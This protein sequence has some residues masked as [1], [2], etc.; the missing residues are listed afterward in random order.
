MQF[1]QK[2]L[3]T[4]GGTVAVSVLA[5]LLAGA[6]FLVY[7]H[8]YRASVDDSSTP[9]TVLVAKSL[10]EKGTSGSIIGENDLFQ[11]T[12]APKSELKDGAI[13]DPASLRGRVAVD[14]IYPGQQLTTADFAP[15]AGNAVATNLTGNERAISI[16]IDTAHGLIGHVQAGD[17]VDVVAGFNVQRIDRNGAPIDQG[18][19]ARPV[20]RILLQDVVVLS[21]P[22]DS[23]SGSI[24]A[25]NANSQITLQVSD[26]QAAEL[27]FASDN[28][29]LW[30]MLRP[31]TGA[32]SDRPSLVSLET[33]L[34]GVKP[35]IVLKS[36]GGRP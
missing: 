15:I 31:K 4:R 2:I 26:E 35:I 21:A 27:A 18:G 11:S 3:S 1:A 19:Q 8:R 22:A 7:L 14:D 30:I 33:L 28:G 20:A 32:R 6:I 17:H 34:L 5:A 23:S 12:T 25:G 36:F 9:M 24:G 10:I 16:P 29:K 13:T